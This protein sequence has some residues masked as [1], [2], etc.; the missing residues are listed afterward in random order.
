MYMYLTFL[1]KVGDSKVEKS[2]FWY[3]F[4]L[5]Y[6][7]TDKRRTFFYLKLVFIQFLHFYLHTL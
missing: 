7:D 4:G 2:V 1:S 5:F 6:E 3:Y